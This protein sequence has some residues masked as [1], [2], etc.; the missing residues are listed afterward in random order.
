MR[1]GALAGQ[2]VN[3]AAKTGPVS[4]IVRK[5]LTWWL[6]SLFLKRTSAETAVAS[7][8]HRTTRTTLAAWKAELGAINAPWKAQLA[9]QELKAAVEAAE[10]DMGLTEAEKA[11]ATPAQR[12]ALAKAQANMD[13][14]VAHGPGLADAITQ[15]EVRA[16]CQASRS[17]SGR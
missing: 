17:E 8:H 15:A 2:A 13:A 5:P 10:A 6:G 16:S 7:S 9:L 14:G 3:T 4:P 12:A 11:A 1:M